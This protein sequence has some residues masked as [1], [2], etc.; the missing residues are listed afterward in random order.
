M[1]HGLAEAE[2]RR[3]LLDLLRREVARAVGEEAAAG[4]QLAG[5]DQGAAG[6][7]PAA[8]DPQV[9]FRRLGLGGGNTAG[10]RD[11]L[12]AELG[13]ELPA[14]LLFDHPSPERL[15]GYLRERVLR[16]PTP[17]QPGRDQPGRDQPGPGQPS[18]PGPGQPSQPGPGQP[19]QP[20]PGQPSQP[21]PERPG[22]EARPGGSA[23]D[24]PVVI[25]SMACRFPGGVRGPEDLWELVADGRDA[26]VDL[27][28]DRGW[29]IVGSFDPD[30]SRSG[31]FYT[32]Q[33]GFL[34]DA[35]GFDAAFFGI[36]PREALAMDPQQRLLLEVS[37]EAL[38][39]A[40][41][42]PFSLRGSPTGVFTGIAVADYSPPW[43]DAPASVEGHL[44]SGT[45]PSVASGRVAY[46]LGLEGPAITVDTA[47]SSSLTALHLAAQAL[48]TGECTLALAGGATVMAT[49]DV[50]VEF[51]RQQGL[52]PDGRC[53]SF[54]QAADGTGWAEGA[55]VVV[56]ERL[57]DARRRGHP[58]LAVVRGSAVNSDGASNGLTA[59]SGP[60]QQ[61]VIRAALASAGLTPSDV[62]VVEAHGTGTRL[63][64]PI[65]AQALLAAYGQDRPADRPLWLGSLKSNVGH[66]VAAAG[67]GGV[68][69]MVLALRHGQLPRTLH[70]DAPSSRVDWSA[71]QVRL[72]TEPVAWQPDG[73][74][75]RRAGVSAFGVSGTNAHVILEEPP[76]A[77]TTSDAPST[78]TV[79]SSSWLPWLLSA[80][81]E[82]A[83]REQAARLLTRVTGEPRPGLVDVGWSLATG[84]A[85]LEHRAA[86]VAADRDG[87]LRGLEALARGES[88]AALIRGTARPG[89]HTD[90]LA[91]LF[92]GQ[93]A[94]RLGMGR[95]LHA[96]FPVFAAAFDAVC[97]SFD[98]HLTR[99]LREVVFGAQAADSPAGGSGPLDRTEFT[100][101]AL[102]ALEVALFELLGS[103]GVRPDFLL[104]HSIGE[105]AAAHVA[106]VLTLDDACT[107]VAARGRL[108]QAMPD[109][110]AMVALRASEEQARDLIAA[111]PSAGQVDVAAVNGPASV[112]ISGDAEPVLEIARR[113]RAQ[114]GK[115]TRL[116]VSH[117]FH[118]AHMDGMLASFRAVVGGLGLR[119]PTIPVVSNLTGEIATADELC[120]AEYWVR[121]VRSAV[122]FRDGVDRLYERGVR[123]YLELG[124]DAALTGLGQ[125]CLPDDA[126]A[127]FV[128]TLR[129]DT[130]E[131][132][133]LARALAHL[134]VCGVAVDWSAYFAG[135]GARR[136][137]LPTY[138]FEHRRFWLGDILP[139]AP[140]LNS[141]SGAA[142]G[143][144]ALG[145]SGVSGVSG[146]G[147]QAGEASRAVDAA[148]WDAVDRGDLTEVVDVDPD[149]ALRT[150][151]PALAAWRTGR[152]DQEALAGWRY[153][154]L[155]RP[156][157]LPAADTPLGRWLLVVPGAT[158]PGGSGA[159]ADEPVDG[160]L[161]DW[162]VRG[163]ESGGGQVAAVLTL[164]TDADTDT[165]G[166]DRA[167]LAARLAE[168][169]G[170]DV[171]LAGVLSLVALDERER[172][173]HPALARGLAATLVLLQALGDAGVAAPLWCAT[174]GAVPAADNAGSAAGTRTGAGNAGRT[175]DGGAASSPVQAQV[176]GLG[177]V[178]A[179]ELPRAW[180][181][182]VDLPATPDE[183][184]ARRLAAVLAGTSG[185]DQVA[186]RASGVF[187]RRLTRPRPDDSAEG[188][189][190][191]PRGTVLI[192]GGTGALGAAVA[193]WCAD[194][195]A[196]RLVLTGRRGEAAPGVPELVADLARRGTEATVVA[197]DA[198]DRDALAAVLAGVPA[199]C[200]L[201]AVVH[202]AGV[203]GEF[204]ALRDVDVAA[205]ADVL[206]GKVAGA[207][208]LDELLGDRELDAF[209]L[210]S[211]IASTWGSGGQCAY[212]AGNAYLDAVAVGRAARGLA[213]SALAWGPWAEGGMAVDPTVAGHLHDRG[214]IPLPPGSAVA[215]LEQAGGS[216]GCLTVADVDWERFAPTFTAA[217]PSPLLADLPEADA[218]LNP[219]PA[220]A[221]AGGA[222]AVP[223]G[224]GAAAGGA[225]ELLGRPAGMPE[226]DWRRLLLDVVRSETAAIL[227]YDSADQVPA[228]RTLSELGSTSLTAVQLRTRLAE[229]TGLRIP[230]TVVY[231][232]PTPAALAAYLQDELP[233]ATA[234]AGASD[235]SSK[236]TDGSAAAGVKA[237]TATPVAMPA[238][239]DDPVVIVGM[240]C[241]F[242]GGVGSPGD[243]WRVAVEGV[244]AVS[245]FPVDRGWDV[246]RLFDPVPGRPGRSY[247]RSGGFLHDAGDFDAE[248]FGVSPREAL[249]MDPQQRLLLEVSWEA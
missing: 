150:V 106:G 186:I 209:V 245:G 229:R 29:D 188:H 156:V 190:W 227:G 172:S 157:A 110:G 18:Q 129:R 92:T 15:A 127:I 89:Q 240:G 34:D 117:A 84:R 39:R 16:S 61:R 9:P 219:Q 126:G 142:R 93:G 180:G 68:I 58:V 125:E 169:A 23:A 159:E 5:E 177:R 166:A 36:A 31:T 191:Q 173:D 26:V 83:L 21:G 216:A 242:P 66:T 185:E 87:M 91:F 107:L 184:A 225:P 134:G 120:S 249:A 94:Q 128:P 4:E 51:S 131:E 196:T 6:E 151:L 152:R 247:V 167:S 119:P 2:Q 135:T 14:T 57:S 46:T 64:D 41:I 115:A 62:D 30:P 244:D 203:A 232:H 37:W 11:A 52:A 50:L 181:G 197:C 155:W 105:L 27:P 70:V 194:R 96:R 118:S 47:C 210:F 147:G 230:T 221:S 48:R 220:T 217:R 82:P 81:S 138:P 13:L 63:G 187:A 144:G 99:P 143:P 223:G 201:T 90:R 213:A 246:E 202:A 95:Q 28:T 158:V 123:T 207:R 204:T 3:I 8:F 56:L 54:A 140:R 136:V 78:P 111:W 226:A 100:Q 198:A 45:L 165:A 170:G 168:A 133:A 43:R 139:A 193:R 44:M 182:L 192:T 241:R 146:A 141:V 175:G 163:V 154:A 24:D 222:A 40:G 161:V 132:P 231:D 116:Q 74:R 178:A 108:M 228:D 189:A 174:R 85:T 53:K 233:G 113:W 214:L 12:G 20:G 176:W 7:R 55:A 38:E 114:G 17:D 60:A 121:Q 171:P 72:L 75:V 79:P 137:D 160:E 237:A 22:A 148:F 236:P 200:P 77:P 195:G 35:A 199:D 224:R 211:S 215:A 71:G 183:A 243:L 1:F 25:V 122:R 102:F 49:I 10:F 109:G 69:K 32:S 145:V 149:A 235:S 208:H 205:F 162:C 98:R 130:A 42:D 101:P 218:A 76:P 212:S 19:S 238:T 234:T 248:F 239:A 67:V 206:S 124:P 153:R 104:G 164:D 103:W 59:P 112:V 80:R 73:S 97:A 88:A 65:E 33:G 86:V 179:L